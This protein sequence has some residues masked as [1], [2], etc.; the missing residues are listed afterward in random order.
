MPSLN[1]VFRR[2]GQRTSKKLRRSSIPK[3]HSVVRPSEDD[4]ISPEPSSSTLPESLLLH[5]F[6]AIT[7]P[8]ELYRLR[9]V[10]KGI[11][12]YVERRLAKVVEMNVKRVNF[13]AISATSV[14]STS[15]VGQMFIYGSKFWHVHPAGYKVIVVCL[16]SQRFLGHYLECPF[17][18]PTW[19]IS[20]LIQN[21]PWR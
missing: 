16:S 6:D 4:E 21:T 18:G 17:C 8:F 13:D 11:K 15:E 10:S 20:N 14:S 2:F 1:Q 19:G 3:L 5:C 9:T 12:R 7:N